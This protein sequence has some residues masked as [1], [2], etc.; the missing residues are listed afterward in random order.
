MRPHNPISH[1]S[2]LHRKKR[3]KQTHDVITPTQ[4]EKP[5][6]A[7]TYALI[8]NLVDANVH[9]RAEVQPVTYAVI[10]VPKQYHVFACFHSACMRHFNVKQ[11]IYWCG[12]SETKNVI[13]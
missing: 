9:S 11:E 12:Q 5:I 1:Y 2:S 8:A 3:A 6:F 13:A 7:C 4:F 10:Q